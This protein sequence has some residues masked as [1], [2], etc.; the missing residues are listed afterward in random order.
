MLTLEDF[1]IQVL[2]P[3]NSILPQEFVLIRD[4][5]MHRDLTITCIAKVRLS[6][7]IS[8]IPGAQYPVLVRDQ[9]T[10]QDQEGNTRSSFML[11]P[12]KHEHAEEVKI[13]DNEDGEWV[14]S[15]PSQHNYHTPTQSEVN[16]GLS[17]I[18]VQRA[19][20]H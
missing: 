11:F 7:I 5:Q 18:V 8:H 2:D 19:L 4:L 3:E 13:C 10:A 1:G 15:L 6:L 12:R 20:L 14:A 9:V 16:K 17:S